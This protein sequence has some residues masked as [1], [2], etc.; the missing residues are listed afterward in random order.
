MRVC[1]LSKH[2]FEQQRESW[3]ERDRKKKE[4]DNNNSIEHA[5]S[6]D[7]DKFNMRLI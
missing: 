1:V 2:H 5:K 4:I 6:S 7:A 3:S